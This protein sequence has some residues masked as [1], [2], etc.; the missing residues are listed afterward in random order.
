MRELVDDLH[1][2]AVTPARF[3]AALAKLDAGA[4]AEGSS[5]RRLAAL[6]SG[7]EAELARLGMPDVQQRR[8]RALRAITADPSLWG[9]RRCC[10]TASTTSARSSCRRFA[11]SPRR[12]RR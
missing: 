9:R 4:P 12:E 2:G 1:A 5:R 3:Q 8:L 6:Y 11:R 10:C 7:Y